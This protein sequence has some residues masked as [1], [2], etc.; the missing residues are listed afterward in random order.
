M[1]LAIDRVSISTIATVLSV[2]SVFIAHNS[3][4]LRNPYRQVQ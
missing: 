1:I 2:F 3:F 4:F